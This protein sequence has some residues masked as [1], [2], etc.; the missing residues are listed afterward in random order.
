VGDDASRNWK[1]CSNWR[2][3]CPLM[4]YRVLLANWKKSAPDAFQRL[5]TPEQAPTSDALLTV[6]ASRCAVVRVAGIHLR[7]R[8]TISIFSAKQNRPRIAFQCGRP[9]SIFEKISIRKRRSR[10]TT[11]IKQLTQDAL[12]CY[13]SGCRGYYLRDRR[14]SPA[15]AQNILGSSRFTPLCVVRRR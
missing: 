1:K 5:S 13:T 10:M 4:N 15:W 14:I 8:Q 9:R 6:E 7:S 12:N 2:E 3:P 11:N